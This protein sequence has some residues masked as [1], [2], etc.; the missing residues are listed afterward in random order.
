MAAAVQDDLTRNNALSVLYQ[1]MMHNF[2]YQ[3]SSA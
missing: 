1:M 2:Q 3:N